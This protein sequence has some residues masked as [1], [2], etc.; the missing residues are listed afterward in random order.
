MDEM[1]GDQG[2]N[3]E[4]YPYGGSYYPLVEDQ[5]NWERDLDLML[6]AGITFIRTAEIVNSW[7]RLQPT[8]NTFDFEKLDKFFELC[9]KKNMKILLGSGSAA[10]PY[11]LHQKD[12]SVNICD[13]HHYPYPNNATYGWACYN[14]P[15]FQKASKIYIE[16][17]VN[18]YKDSQSLLA[19]QIN[20]EIGYPFMPLYS[21]KMETY[22]FCDYCQV[23]FRDWLKT[24]YKTLDELTKAWSW[25]TT[26]T[27][28]QHWDD[29]I[30]P[31]VKPS[32]W[33][34]VTRWLD[35]RLFHMDVITNQV[36]RE[37]DL[38]KSL[39]QSHPTIANIF[40]L[41]SQDLFGVMAGLDQFEI[42]KHVDIIGYDLYPGSGN[43]LEKRPEFSSMFFD[44]LQ[45]VAKPLNKDYWLSEAE[46]GPIGGWVLGPDYSTNEVDIIRN[47]LETIGHGVTSI[48][49]QLFKEL[50][51]QPLHWGGIVNLDG[52]K[53]ERFEACKKIGELLKKH[54]TFL[55]STKSA[56]SKVA[57]FVSKENQ[58]ILNGIDQEKFLYE[59]L[60]GVYQYFWYKKISIEFI[61]HEQMFSGYAKKYNLIIF[62]FHPVV[63][64]EL[65]HSI[66]EYLENGVSIVLSARFGYMDK[67]G[68]YNKQ[69]L[70]EVLKNYLDL[71]VSNCKKQD[72]IVINYQDQMLHGHH[73]IEEL[74]ITDDWKVLATFDNNDPA[75]V[76]KNINQSNLIYFATHPG[77]TYLTN[78]DKSLMN[79]LD[80]IVEESC[81]TH[82]IKLVG[83]K[84]LT[85]IIDTHVLE[86]EQKG[87]VILTH[88][89]NNAD[90][91]NLLNISK[92][93]TLVLPFEIQKLLDVF[94]E[95]DILVEKVGLSTHVEFEFVED[96][97]LVWEYLK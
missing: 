36:K 18:R 25:T 54:A 48:L 64:E 1:E 69:P 93:V 14:N 33:A 77:H 7:D 23:E 53:T 30:P 3:I 79:V 96:Q 74:K 8:E 9:E 63:S 66:I 78:P 61:T 46:A 12:P 62:P 43:K 56:D 2:M 39:D 59:E 19:Y 34:S 24:K 82:T 52:S 76:S 71:N 32:S 15:T 70:G 80:T 68:W 45:S 51:F 35:W 6:E 5:E 88:F 26:T 86:N 97:F 17:L 22:C 58:I 85:K 95:N 92:K 13:Q 55:R 20:N 47:Q 89:L 67:K 90:R 44:H 27:A 11:W 49:Y 72:N 41:K 73:H 91:K 28:H 31:Y 10:P 42:A 84:K 37:N 21:E 16:T 57:I 75:V 40:Y 4:G 60:R 50:P 38:I 83:D 94:S 29:V 81:M 65:Q 87:W